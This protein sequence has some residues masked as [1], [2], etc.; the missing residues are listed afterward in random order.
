MIG[1]DEN[2]DYIDNKFDEQEQS[3]INDGYSLVGIITI[4]NDDGT[5]VVG[6][7]K[8]VGNN[9]Q[10]NIYYLQQNHKRNQKK[11]KK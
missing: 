9:K 6:G 10:K 1:G 4:F 5:N 2:I 8:G 3:L 11:T 7:V